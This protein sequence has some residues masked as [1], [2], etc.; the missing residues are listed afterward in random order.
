MVVVSAEAWIVI[1]AVAALLLVALVA[2]F[3]LYKRRRISLSAPTAEKE[4]T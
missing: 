4:L 1:A 3:V 2:G